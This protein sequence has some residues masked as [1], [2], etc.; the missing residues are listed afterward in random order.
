MK[1]VP[2]SYQTRA[3]QIMM[4]QASLG[5]FLDPG[6]GKTSTWLGAFTTLKQLGLA[7]KMLVI[8]PLKPMYGTWPTEIDKFD[9]FSHLTWCFL[10]GPDKDWHLTNTEADI[11]LIN[12]EGIQ[13]LTSRVDPSKIA[14]VLCIDESTKFKTSTSKRFKYMRP[15]FHRFHYRWIGTGTPSP[16]GLED[17]FGQLFILDAGQALGKYI[18]HFRKQWFYTEHWNPYK[19]LPLPH[20]FD[21]ITDA[22]APLVLVM[23]AKDYLD[24]PELMTVDKFITLPPKIASMYKEVEEEYLAEIPDTNSVLVAPTEAAAGAKCRQICNGAVYVDTEQVKLDPPTQQSNFEELHDEKLDMLDELLEEIGE[25]PTIVVYEFRHD[26]H[27]ITRRHLD[28][29]CLTDMSGETLQHI[30]SRFNE[31]HIT[32][33]LIQSSQAHGLNIQATCHHMIWFGLTWNW[34]DYKQ[35]VDRLYRQGQSASMVMVYRILAE[36]TLDQDIAKR[37]EHKMEVE[38]D[39]KRRADSKRSEVFGET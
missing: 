10:H 11:Y 37:L 19:W 1:F 25:H 39:V 27:R 17:L 31:G 15:Y 26:L 21:E 9:E 3:M 4:S 29:P 33:L 24:M 30:I 35:M 36:G 23:E 13:W 5:L 8:A 7:D 28:W 18:T 14:D 16:N 6:L 20:A 34:E 22:I 32:R 2:H 12:P 38:L